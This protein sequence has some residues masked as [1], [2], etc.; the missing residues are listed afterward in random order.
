VVTMTYR[1]P[2]VGALFALVAVFL[3]ACGTADVGY[4]QPTNGVTSSVTFDQDGVLALAPSQTVAVN[5]H[6]DVDTVTLSLAGDYL[7][8]FLDS[9]SVDTSSGQGTFKLH[10]PSSPSTFSILAVAGNAS[11][12]LDVAVSATG[13]AT[14]DV[15]VN[16]TGDR[17]IPEVAASVFLETTCALL[18][19]AA[20]DGSPLVL[21]TQGE[22]LVIPSVPTDGHVAVAVRIAHYATGCVD[23]ASLSP[24]ET[25]SVTVDVFDL[26]LDLGDTTLETRFTFT[27]IIADATTLA[28]YFDQT[29]SGAVLAAAFPT[30]Q[31]ESYDLLDAMGA[32][33]TSPSDFAA[34]RSSMGWNSATQSWLDA[35]TP[36]LTARASAWLHASANAGLGDLTGHLAA[37]PMTPTFTPK[38]L[39]A[40]DATK[41]GISA[42]VPFSWTGQPADVL[43]VTGNVTIVPSALACAG[44]D[45]VAQTDVPTSTGV[46]TAL[47]LGIDCTGLGSALVPAGYGF[48]TCDATCVAA[49]CVSALD[50]M[51]TSGAAALSKPSEALT[52]AITVAAPVQV[53]DT[54]NVTSFM[55]AWVGSFSYGYTSK[56]ATQGVAK[57]AYGVVPN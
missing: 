57:G 40:L 3:P 51:W 14:V 11:A 21:G 36:T 35:H 49:L 42:P 10:A 50:A 32:A 12:R 29:V 41:A 28:G 37:D 47:A 56:I 23:I 5:L 45:V 6:S 9:D 22:Q 15:T 39:G 25:H 33:S 44:A 54:A 48:D 19:G 27:P 55:G 13:F 43:S 31:T 46:A 34:A 1:G 24:N 52:L 17:P 16:Y 18:D 20:M 2:A 8:A 4:R 26:P 30:T 7:D 53:G 38:T